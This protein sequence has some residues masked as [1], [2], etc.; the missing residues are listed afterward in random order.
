MAKSSNARPGSRKRAR[1][2]AHP[3]LEYIQVEVQSLLGQS[4]A[5]NTRRVYQNSLSLLSKC[6]TLYNL[7][8]EWPV[9]VDHLQIFFGYMS[10]NGMSANTMQSYL[11]GISYEHKMNMLQYTTKAFVVQ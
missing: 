10:L 7:Q 11:S 4:M 8:S 6:R 1:S 2:D 5:D 9:P 3:P